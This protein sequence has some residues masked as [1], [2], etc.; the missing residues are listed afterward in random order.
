[1]AQF[2]N[3]CSPDQVMSFQ[4]CNTY[5]QSHIHSDTEQIKTSFASIYTTNPIFR[6]DEFEHM[7][8]SDCYITQVFSFNAHPQSNTSW[9]MVKRPT[10]KQ[11]LSVNEMF[12]ISLTHYDL[13][14]TYDATEAKQHRM[15]TNR[16]AMGVFFRVIFIKNQNF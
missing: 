16:R 4:C 10:Q 2:E 3:G 11:Q 7:L 1:M 12:F 15:T 6:H 9:R 14:T 13:V 5:I 8:I